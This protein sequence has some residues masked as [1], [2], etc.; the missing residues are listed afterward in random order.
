MLPPVRG[1][2]PKSARPI[3]LRP[4]PTSPATPRISASSSVNEIPR[5]LRVDRFLTQSAVM[6]GP[7]CGAAVPAVTGRPTMCWITSSMLV[8]SRCDVA[9]ISPSRMTEMRSQTRKISD[10]LW[11]T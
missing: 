11:E 9:I 3:S 1:D 7:V 8:R 4:D 5:S 6:E 10:I 2:I